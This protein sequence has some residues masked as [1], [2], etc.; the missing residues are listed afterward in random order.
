MKNKKKK[1]QLSHL[2]AGALIG[3]ISAFSGFFLVTCMLR[4]SDA[5]LGPIK[6]NGPGE[7]LLYFAIAMVA[8]WVGIAVHELGHLLAG[9]FQ[10]FRF[11]LFTV[12][13]LGIR[14]GKDHLEVFFNR[15]INSFGGLAA[16]FPATWNG[17]D[18]RKKFALVVAAGPISSLLFGVVSLV[19]AWT[20]M[21][22]NGPKAFVFAL[23]CL[24]V[25]SLLLF[26]VTAI[27]NRTGGF[28]SD[29]GRFLAL[30]RGGDISAR[31]QA[32]LALVALLCAGKTP[33]ELP[34]DLVATIS[35]SAGDDISLTIINGRYL[36]FSYHLDRG[37]IEAARDHAQFLIDHQTD[38]PQG[39]FQ[40]YFM[41]EV[42]F[43]YAFVLKDM[44]DVQVI[45]ENIKNGAD[46]D[47]DVA[48]FRVKAAL[49]LLQGARDQAILF[50]RL[51][52]QKSEKMP[53]AG[54]R[55]F[56]TKW[57]GKIITEA[58]F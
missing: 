21:L 26:V 4:G 14:A 22:N 29:G 27:P 24:G 38:M 45:W 9:L 51:G 23:F 39:Y 19:F 10:G 47:A 56:E 7:G 53:F 30:L 49:E 57:F 33:G 3:S 17:E 8:I 44:Q 55:N 13:F 6:P 25:L 36:A 40:R 12:G 43:F 31:E 20:W 58:H 42:I 37:E 35:H 16:T 11:A 52:L 46:R 28:T 41:K 1:V 34:A 50:A 15:D 2:L 5:L 48:T 54:L 18:L 32:N